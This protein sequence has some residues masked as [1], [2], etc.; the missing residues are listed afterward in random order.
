MTDETVDTYLNPSE[1]D[2][3]YNLDLTND[4]SLDNVRDLF[5]IG[6]WTGLRISDLKRINQFLFTKKTIVISETQKTGIKVEIP[7]HH[8][9]R[10]TLTKRNN[11]LPKNISTQKFNDYIKEV[12]RLAGITEITLGNIKNPKTNRKEKGHYPKYLLITSHTARR[13]FA[14]N[15]YG[16]ELSDKAIM[17]ITGH[18]SHTQFLKYIKTTD[19]EHIE[20]VAKLWEQQ[21]ELKNAKPILKSVNF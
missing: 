12:C 19:K 9:V 13:S 8:Q 18:K 5:I 10:N 4:N 14:T 15:L 2:L 6:L 21:E 7:I 1:I 20:K 3:I 17:S 11:E 16:T